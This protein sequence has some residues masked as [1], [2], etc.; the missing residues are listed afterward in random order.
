MASRARTK[1]PKKR[2]ILI[3]LPNGKVV[4]LLVAK[5]AEE[6]NDHWTI[7]RLADYELVDEDEVED[8]WD[9]SQLRDAIR[10]RIRREIRDETDQCIAIAQRIRDQAYRE[11]AFLERI[12][13]GLKKQHK[14][15]AWYRRQ[16]TAQRKLIKEL[17]EQ[18][19]KLQADVA[20]LQQKI[21]RLID[22]DETS[23]LF[24]NAREEAANTMPGFSIDRLL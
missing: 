9:W 14:R 5:V 12:K 10:S 22:Q 6:V 4:D 7:K 20:E 1:K 19:S 24:E 3:P 15:H 23:A 16:V 2:K 13:P 11:R 17:K 8:Y 21:P 18:Q